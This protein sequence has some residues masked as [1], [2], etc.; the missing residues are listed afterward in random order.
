MPAELAMSIGSIALNA[1]FALVA[2]SWK[3]AVGEMKRRVTVMEERSA[4]HNDSI[5]SLDERSK[6]TVQMLERIEHTMV[7]RAEWEARHR[8]TDAMLER[9]LERLDAR[10]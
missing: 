8:G 10:R 4:K 2:F 3:E 1:I 9:I 5:V 6:G 7:P